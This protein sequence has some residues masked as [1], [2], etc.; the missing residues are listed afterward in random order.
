MPSHFSPISNPFALARSGRRVAIAVGLLGCAAIGPLAMAQ[1]G[2]LQSITERE[3]QRRTNLVKSAEGQLTEGQLL[4]EK[5]KPEE[6]AKAFMAAYASLPETVATEGVR[7]RLRAAYC[8]AA[9]IWAKNLLNEGHYADASKVIDSVL[10]KD[11]DPDYRD[12]LKLRKQAADSDRYPPALTAKHIADTKEATRLLVLAASY[13]DLGDADRALATY[14]DVLRIDPYNTAARRGM[15]KVEQFRSRYHNAARDHTRSSML[16]AVDAQWEDAIPP[17]DKLAEMLASSAGGGSVTSTGRDVI[18]QKLRTLK[19]PH[20]EFNNAT[21]D[22][23]V[24]YMRVTSR[25]LDQDGRGVDFIVSLEPEA[26]NHQLSLNLSNV[27]LEELLRY[28]TQISG[29]AFRV[30]NNAVVI[31]SLTERSTTLITKSYKVPPD[32]IQTA[33]VDAAAGAPGAAADPFAKQGAPTGVA[34]GLQVRRMGAREFL[35]GRGVAFPEG[36]SA[37]FSG[38]SSTLIVRNTADNVNMVDMLVE[39][40]LASG[41]KQ[42][43]ITVKMIDVSQTRLNELGF[44]WEAGSFNVPGSNKVFASGGGI[45]GTSAQAFN[46]AMPAG[47]NAAATLIT[48]GLRSSGEILGKPGLDGLIAASAGTGGAPSSDS[49]S[50]AQFALVGVFSDPSFQ[51]AIRSLSQSKGVD[52]V[53]APTITTKSGQKSSVRVVRE[54]PYPTEFDPPQIPQSVNSGT[55]GNGGGGGGAT[56]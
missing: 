17:S 33:A 28:V 24:E 10:D 35:E 42:A 30:E 25:N 27:P 38:G 22:E 6:A 21:L 51:M 47:G 37:S 23:V 45:N 7:A 8:S 48:G 34:N 15:E 14:R 56:L 26:R 11:V 46:D 43:V 40:A 31:G 12:A 55:N 1:S 29:A 49:R 5:D 18:E 39:T 50:P 36:A 44:D 41:S 4:L 53:A 3:I 9:C 54:F 52:L 16:S 19:I 2:S 32:F 13:V 20:V